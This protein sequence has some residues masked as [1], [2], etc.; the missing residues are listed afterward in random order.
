MCRYKAYGH[1][2]DYVEKMA[3]LSKQAGIET[4]Q[5]EFLEY[6]KQKHGRKSSFWEKL[7]S[8]K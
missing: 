1:A 6:L 7:D 5:T 3:Q 4:R 2:A 8:R